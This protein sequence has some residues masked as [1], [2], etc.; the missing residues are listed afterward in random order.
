VYSTSPFDPGSNVYRSADGGA[1]WQ[2]GPSG[3]SAIRNDIA[4]P[5]ARTCYTAGNHGTITRTVNGSSFAAE[6]SPVTKDL[7]GITCPGLTACYAA[8]DG[9]TILARR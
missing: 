5:A 7:Y 9:G 4:C 3:S 8:G 6:R 2:G 1:A